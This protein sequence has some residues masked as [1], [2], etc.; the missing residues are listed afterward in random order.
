MQLQKYSGK[1]WPC[2]WTEGGKGTLN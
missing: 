1:I 2:A